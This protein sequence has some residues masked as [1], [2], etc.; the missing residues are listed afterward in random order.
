VLPNGR[1]A[2]ESTAVEA[3]RWAGGTLELLFVDGRQVYDYPCDAALYERFL[4]APSKGRFVNEVLKPHADA[5]GHRPVPYDWQRALLRREFALQAETFE[6]PTYVFTDADVLAWIDRHTRAL[7][8]DELHALLHAAG[9][10]AALHDGDLQITQP[11]SCS[12]GPCA[13]LPGRDSNPNYQSQNL[14]CCQ[15]HHPATGPA[16]SIGRRLRRRGGLG[17]PTPSGEVCS[18]LH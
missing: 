17:G 16:S 2:W 18:A 14:A 15:L 1:Q 5:L 12:P 10:R 4:A 8:R 11:G 13:E 7:A 3:F 9:L 6:S